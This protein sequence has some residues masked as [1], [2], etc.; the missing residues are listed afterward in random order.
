MNTNVDLKNVSEGV[1]EK[2]KKQSYDH[3]HP[4]NVDRKH[5]FDFIYSLFCLNDNKVARA[6]GI[7]RST[8]NRYRRGVFEPSPQMKLIIAQKISLLGNY[9]VDSAV[10]FGEDLIYSEW[11]TNKK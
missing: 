2:C 10:L 9:P 8:M 11:R 5:R 1:V 7:D 4:V 3:F 6:I